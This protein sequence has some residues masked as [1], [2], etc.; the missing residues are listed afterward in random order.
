SGVGPAG[1]LAR[2]RIA[3]THDLPGVGANLQDHPIAPV[4]ARIRGNESML[5]AESPVQMLRY[6][7]RRRGMLSSNIGEAA[8]FVRSQPALQAPAIEIVFAPVLFLG[9]G[10]VKPAEH[11][12]TL[13]VAVVAPESRGHIRLACADPFAKPLIDPD[14]LGDARDRATLLTAYAI[15]M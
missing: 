9:E 10:L 5:A 13:G 11:G 7:L 8:A 2:H 6:F 14:Y 15:G 1:E 4:W 3:L 12:I